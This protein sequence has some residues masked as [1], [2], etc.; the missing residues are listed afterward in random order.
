VIVEPNWRESRAFVEP[1]DWRR[2]ME[3]L[4]QKQE[5]EG[6]GVRE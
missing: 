4:A 1:L 5:N 2:Q 3:E 6:K